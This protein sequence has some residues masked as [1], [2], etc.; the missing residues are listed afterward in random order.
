MSRR[1]E[2]WLFTALLAV[3]AATR[4]HRLGAESIWLDEAATFLRATRSVP[5]VVQ[6]SI[7]RMHNPSY[8]LMMHYW[9]L[10]YT[11]LEITY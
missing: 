1:T 6:N 3:A 8:F 11:L 5:D 10:I 7:E 9:L 2:L 4:C